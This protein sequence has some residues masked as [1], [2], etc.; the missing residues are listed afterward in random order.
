M[1]SLANIKRTR[2]YWTVSHLVEAHVTN[3]FDTAITYLLPLLPA[4]SCIELYS[5]MR[6]KT[7]LKYVADHLSCPGTFRAR[8]KA[9]VEPGTHL[10]TIVIALFNSLITVY[11]REI[12]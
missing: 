8:R 9:N 5:I 7:E 1:W 11:E 4:L 3:M 2:V 12:L 10:L 6:V